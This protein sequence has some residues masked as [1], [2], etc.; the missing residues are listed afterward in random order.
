MVLSIL[1]EP[2]KELKPTSHER[3]LKELGEKMEFV[4]VRPG[5]L[6]SEPKT[7]QG[8]LTSDTSVCGP[9]HREDVASLVCKC[10]FSAKAANQ[11]YSAVD[12]EQTQAAASYETVEL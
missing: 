8:V 2:P 9:I 6:K 12:K 10:L 11:V 3:S 5:G 1:E 7:D 4:I